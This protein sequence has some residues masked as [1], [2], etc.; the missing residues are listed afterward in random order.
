MIALL[1]VIVFGGALTVV[2]VYF[3]LVERREAIKRHNAAAA[4]RA[5][6]EQRSG[7]DRRKGQRLA[8]G[9]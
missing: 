3:T 6:E 2:G 5:S 7:A 1:P 8:A 4:Q 9:V